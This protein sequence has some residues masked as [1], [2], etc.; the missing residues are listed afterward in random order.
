MQNKD[1]NQ[2]KQ[3]IITFSKSIKSKNNQIKL[4]KTNLNL[5]TISIDILSGVIV[6]TIIGLLLDNIFNSKP[7]FLIIS[8]CFGYVA[9]FRNIIKK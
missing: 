6:G 7:I 5:L 3:D 8:I 9:S 4:K 1:L 2:L